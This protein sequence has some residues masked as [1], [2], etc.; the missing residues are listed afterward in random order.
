[1]FGLK[2]LTLSE[3]LVKM[4][5]RASCSTSSLP[6]LAS[7]NSRKAPLEEPCAVGKELFDDVAAAAAAAPPLD[8]D[9]FRLRSKRA[10]LLSSSEELDLR[11]E[12]LDLLLLIL[13]E[14][15]FELPLPILDP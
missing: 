12:S 2:L 6:L 1:M 14:P 5:C 9:V 13:L 4:L 11:R 15:G 10:G 7:R 3:I 8:L